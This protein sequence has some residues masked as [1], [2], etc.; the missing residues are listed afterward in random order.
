MTKLNQAI[1]LHEEAARQLAQTRTIKA[2]ID[3]MRALQE[4]LDMLLSAVVDSDQWTSEDEQAFT[5]FI[6]QWEQ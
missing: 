1:R 5:A 6:T 4:A 2:R 3:A